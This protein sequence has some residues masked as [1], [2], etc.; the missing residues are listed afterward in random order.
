VIAASSSTPDWSIGPAAPLL[1]TMVRRPVIP[2]E[3]R[4]EIERRILV[5]KQTH[6]DVLNWL[7]RKGYICEEKTLRRR[8]KK[9]GITRQGV[10]DDPTMVDYINRQFHTTLNDDE[11]IASHLIGLDYSITVTRVKVVRLAH[12][13]RHRQLTQQQKQEKWEK[14]F[15]LVDEALE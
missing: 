4:L 10:D 15:A 5:E 2:D 13:W 11:T 6:R 7:A 8:C 1:A 9:W 14:T 3:L 12:G